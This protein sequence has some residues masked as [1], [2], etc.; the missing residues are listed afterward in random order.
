MF[1]NYLVASWKDALYV[2]H[3]SLYIQILHIFISVQQSNIDLFHR[4]CRNTLI[5]LIIVISSLKL[6]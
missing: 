1:F 3:V 4:V 5:C 2:L 6:R